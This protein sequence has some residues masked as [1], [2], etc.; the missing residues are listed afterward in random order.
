[1]IV[2]LMQLFLKPNVEI[3]DRDWDIKF[4]LDKLQ[5]KFNESS[6]PVECNEES[7]KIDLARKEEQIKK[8]NEQIMIQQITYEEWQI[9]LTISQYCGVAALENYNQDLEE[10]FN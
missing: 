8:L 1:M 9:P 10:R 3:K 6:N 2:F 7:L 5:Q 4:E